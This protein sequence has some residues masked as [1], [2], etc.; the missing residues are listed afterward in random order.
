MSYMFAGAS[1]F[2]QNIGGW[3]M[4]S[5]NTIEG[6]FHNATSFNQNIGNWNT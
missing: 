3:N 5:V 4:S 2:N 1:D 6:M